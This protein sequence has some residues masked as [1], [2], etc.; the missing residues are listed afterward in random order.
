MEN[1]QEDLK[2]TPIREIDDSHALVNIRGVCKFIESPTVSNKRLYTFFNIYDEEGDGIRVWAKNELVDEVMY[3]VQ[4]NQTYEITNALV[5]NK[6]PRVNFLHKDKQLVLKGDSEIRLCDRESYA[7]R[8]EYAILPLSQLSMEAPRPFSVFGRITQVDPVV[9]KPS[10]YKE[11][12]PMRKVS[13][14]DAHGDERQM[15]L[16]RNHTH[17]IDQKDVGRM[18]YLN[19]VRAATFQGK[20]EIRNLCDTEITVYRHLE[21]DEN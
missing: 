19:G 18:V 15:T 5:E 11:N 1:S 8:K 9:Y 16:W 3:K 20:C 17:E 14:I 2:F 21:L 13:I 7:I 12:E 10:K 4:P 6:D